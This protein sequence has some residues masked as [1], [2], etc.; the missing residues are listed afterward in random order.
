MFCI[1]L[2][3]FHKHNRDETM[4]KIG[5]FLSLLVLS[6]CDSSVDIPSNYSANDKKTVTIDADIGSLEKETIALSIGESKTHETLSGGL[7]IFH[8]QQPAHQSLTLDTTIPVVQGGENID[9]KLFINVFDSPYID[10]RSDH[11][12]TRSNKNNQAISS[13]SLMGAIQIPTTSQATDIGLVVSDEIY[14]INDDDSPKLGKKLQSSLYFPAKSEA[15]DY[16]IAISLEKDGDIKKSFVNINISETESIQ[17]DIKISTEDITNDKITNIPI[18]VEPLLIEVE[19]LSEF[20]LAALNYNAYMYAYGNDY[21]F[22]ESNI[23]DLADIVVYE[24]LSGDILKKTTASIDENFISNITPGKSESF[25]LHITPKTNYPFNMD[26][27]FY[28]EGET[29]QSI[30]NG[31]SH[32][33]VDLL[34][35]ELNYLLLNPSN[36]EYQLDIYAPWFTDTLTNYTSSLNLKSEQGTI[37]DEGILELPYRKSFTVI[38][39]KLPLLLSINAKQAYSDFGQ[40]G[41]YGLDDWPNFY[42]GIKPKNPSMTISNN[43]DDYSTINDIYSYKTPNEPAQSIFF[44]IEEKNELIDLWVNL[45]LFRMIHT[46]SNDTN[47]SGMITIKIKAPNGAFI[48]SEI[49]DIEDNSL[50]ENL[51][52]MRGRDFNEN[53]TYSIEIDF[54]PEN[55]SDDIFINFTISASEYD[56]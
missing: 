55:E 36:D 2:I 25:Y 8:I 33:G 29:T 12:S 23:N 48:S 49:I 1:I 51:F 28:I 44:D 9:Y 45:E 4:I 13:I 19:N 37:F 38:D 18:S 5:L 50:Y 27:L 14:L 6:G 39:N 15:S 41:L 10:T 30:L 22:L 21:S 24:S 31:E 11:N 35:D 46:G 26:L 52:L 56:Y 7:D 40:P 54:I 20:T 43:S 47:I 16:Y 53:G 42:W 32:I 17:P 34:Y 3:I